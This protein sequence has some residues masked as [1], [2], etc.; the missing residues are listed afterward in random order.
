[1]KL[2]LYQGQFKDLHSKDYFHGLRVTSSQLGRC[3]TPKGALIE[4]HKMG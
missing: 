1:M 4:T 2:N 3:P